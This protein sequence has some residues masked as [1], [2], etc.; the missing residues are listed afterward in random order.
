MIPTPQNEEGA[1]KIH[2][3]FTR[4]LTILK[5][6]LVAQWMCDAWSGITGKNRE[7]EGEGDTGDGRGTQIDSGDKKKEGEP[8][9]QGGSD[10]EEQEGEEDTGDRRETQIDSGDKKKEGEPRGQDG[11]DSE[12]QEGETGDGRGNQ[13]DSGDKKKEGELRGQG[14]SDSEKQ[15]GDTGDRRGAQ[16]DSGDKKKEGEPRGHGGKRPNSEG[17]S[18]GEKE[19]QRG[20]NG[21]E[22]DKPPKEHRPELICRKE[23]GH[24]WVIVLSKDDYNISTVSQ[25]GNCLISEDG[26]F[27]LSSFVG[28]LLVTYKN[29][30][31]EERV[32]VFRNKKPLIFKLR[33]DWEGDGRKVSKM[34]SGHYIVMTPKDWQ[35]EGQ[36]P[37]EQDLCADDSFVAHY[38]YKDVDKKVNG[39][40]GQDIQQGRSTYELKGETIYDDSGQG[41]LFVENTPRLHLQ[42]PQEIK[43]VRIGKEGGAPRSWGKNIEIKPAVKCLG[44]ADI[45]RQQQGWFYIRIYD[46]KGLTDGGVFRYLQGLR[47]ILVDDISYSNEMFI[48]PS[49]NGYPPT[50]LQFQFDGEISIK[51][52][53]P[54]Q[55]IKRE[56]GYLLVQPRQ[57]A[58]EVKC[59]LKS[60]SGQVWTR[61]RLPRVWWRMEQGR[62]QEKWCATPFKMTRWKFKDLASKGE[63]IRVK[64]PSNV[65]TTKV[66]FDSDLG[67]QY[68][69]QQQEIKLPFK[70][71]QYHDQ[72]KQSLDKKVC[73]NLECHDK[74]LS[75]VHVL[76]DPAIEEFM[77]TPSTAEVGQPVKLRWAI[78][79]G[80]TEDVEVFL[81]DSKVESRGNKLV[82]LRKTT[83]F[84]LKL[85]V[86]KMEDEL[87]QL[88]VVVQRVSKRQYAKVRRSGGDWRRGKGFSC[89]EIKTAGLTK[90]NVAG[91]SLPLDLRRRTVHDV[92]IEILKELINAR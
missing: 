22:S 47:K 65:R 64:L 14:G 58:D 63:A 66:G 87:R 30:R 91:H 26:E 79:N 19:P 37:V 2:C 89:E 41:P 8:R 90:D 15:E 68:R 56:D 23:R 34:T 33:R 67:Q 35:R 75:L 20:P 59:E 27:R 50:K 53:T 49:A 74:M 83:L 7:A 52:F 54:N 62:E 51:N 11:S 76:A 36:P 82:T 55:H 13:I 70:N 24:Q 60:D 48:A 61:I 29:R 25:N 88:T 45:L 92:N 69:P 9:G 84:T 42:D 71:F 5:K 3:L 10:S 21:Q 16:I 81:S 57:C 85:R 46:D 32:E 72:I 4:T 39:F 73:L 43:W 44:L 12:E 38:F 28:D 80:E 1:I 18:G 78:R 6:L 86:P 17:N 31:Q 77:A 40:K